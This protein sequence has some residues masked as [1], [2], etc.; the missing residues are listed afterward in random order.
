MKRSIIY[1]IIILLVLGCK[2][3]EPEKETFIAGNT[4]RSVVIDED[5]ILWFGTESGIS[6]F[7]GEEWVN[8]TYING[9]PS[10][11]IF[12]IE[13]R[14]FLS[15]TQILVA[16]VRGVGIVNKILNM[17]KSIVTINKANSDIR[18]NEIFAIM[19]DH[20]GG[21]WIS[22]REG[23]TV[24]YNNNWL[25]SETDSITKDYA[26]TDIAAGP[27]TISY[28]CFYGQ[29]IALMDLDVDA[30]TTVTYYEWPLSPLPSM[31]IQAIYVDG[32]HHQWIGTDNGL[33]FHGNFDPTKEW[34]LYYES[35]GLIDNN[36]L[37]VKSDDNGITWVGTSSGVSRFDGEE[38][39]SFTEEDGLAG[40]IVFC[41]AIDQDN[42]VWF[43]TNNGAS[44]FIQDEWITY[45]TEE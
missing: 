37:A 28:V 32:Y 33:A 17:A 34:Y 21:T 35:D 2:D 12:D 23:L 10:D 25:I 8:Y 7:N 39:I 24:H 22:T 4:V 18:S 5:G 45:R 26:I 1:L 15:E 38:W 27:D 3:D 43:G 40:N 29:G 20:I 9:L 42:S 31:N 30:L 11:T 19:E 16:T 14:H 41:I 6:S 13:V 44:H 36:V